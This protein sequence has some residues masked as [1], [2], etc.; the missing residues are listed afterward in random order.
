MIGTSCFALYSPFRFLFLWI[1]NWKDWLYFSREFSCN[2]KSDQY[3]PWNNGAPL[4]GNNIIFR[5]LFVRTN[6]I[7]RKLAIITYGASYISDNILTSKYADKLIKMSQTMERDREGGREKG[8]NHKNL[9]NIPIDFSFMFLFHCINSGTVQKKYTGLY[10]L[11][12]CPLT[13]LS[14][15]PT[16]SVYLM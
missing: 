5:V 2:S 7:F 12:Y 10:V 8:K 3:I 4:I 16:V 11:V 1:F 6:R 9:S 13:I 14:Q 15:H